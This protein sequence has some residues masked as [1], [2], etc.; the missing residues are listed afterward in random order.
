M[1]SVGGTTQLR[2]RV[3]PVPAAAGSLVAATSLAAVN[4]TVGQLEL[5]LII[6]SAVAGLLVAVG[7]CL[8]HAPRP[9]A[10][11]DDGGPGRPDHRR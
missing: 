5:I 8:G 2:L 6:G 4:S 7:V 1:T 11:R 9:A 10:H 3:M